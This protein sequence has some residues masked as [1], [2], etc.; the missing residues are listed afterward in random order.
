[1]AGLS[2]LAKCE[3]CG[4]GFNVTKDILKNREFY[5]NEQSIFLTYYDCPHCGRRHFVQIDDKVSKQKLATISV[6]FAK[7]AAA[8][9]KGKDISKKQSEIF[10]KSRQDLS[11]YRMTLMKEFTGK[12][13]Y[14]GETGARFELRFS[15]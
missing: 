6:K 5:V 11:D 13:V 9:R 10:K 3:D 4:E 1:M 2:F 8:K 7:I 12:L 15:V 14:D